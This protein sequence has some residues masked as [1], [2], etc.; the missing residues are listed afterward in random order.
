MKHEVERNTVATT[1]AITTTTTTTLAYDI[2]RVYVCIPY[3]SKT[4]MH[5]I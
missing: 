2:V 3:E 1:A 5:K 4:C